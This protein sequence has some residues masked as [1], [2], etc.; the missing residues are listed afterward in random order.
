MSCVYGI[1][2]PSL[3]YQFDC[4]R[5]DNHSNL[6]GGLVQNQVLY[7]ISFV[8]DVKAILLTK[9]SLLKKEWVGSDYVNIIS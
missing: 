9:W 2:A 4:I 8:L 6:P 1:V 3:H 7:D 5:H